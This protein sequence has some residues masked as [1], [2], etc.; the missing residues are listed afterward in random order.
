MDNM[1]VTS[2]IEDKLTLP[3][4]ER[5]IEWLNIGVKTTLDGKEGYLN[6]NGRFYS[7]ELLKKMIKEFNEKTPFEVSYKIET[8]DLQCSIGSIV[9]EDTKYKFK[10]HKTLLSHGERCNMYIH[11]DTDKIH[12]VAQRIAEGSDDFNTWLSCD[13]CQESYRAFR[14]ISTDHLART[15]RY[16]KRPIG[17]PYCQNLEERPAKKS[18]WETR[19]SGTNDQQVYKED[20][21]PDEGPT[22]KTQSIQEGGYLEI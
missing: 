3:A 6:E 18:L 8:P 5:T 17:C 10:K 22:Y 11:H 9:K 20:E 16:I 13:K 1:N 7:T 19:F 4:D 21:F 14:I 2:K 15:I 12:T